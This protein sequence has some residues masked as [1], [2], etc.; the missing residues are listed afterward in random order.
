M[1]YFND[2]KIVF[3]PKANVSAGYDEGYEAG[4]EAGKQ[5]GGDNWYDTFWDAFQENGSRTK[6][7]DAFAYW[8]TEAF[9]PK[10]DIIVQNAGN[11]SMFSNAKIEGSLS[12]I[13]NELGIVLRF[14]G[15]YS[16]ATFSNS[17][18][19][20]I[21]ISSSI[22]FSTWANTF[23]GCSNLKTLKLPELY[24][25]ASFNNTFSG[26]TE[27]EEVTLTGTIG[28]S[29]SFQDS[30]KLTVGS[31]KNVLA[32]LAV[33]AGTDKDGVYKVTFPPECW[34]RLEASGTSPVGG[35]WKE[36]VQFNYGFSV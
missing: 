9:K 16:S 3:S 26:C 18:F 5:S 17:S 33:Y 25:G 14:N 20:E 4:F 34:E 10:Y 29:I 35:T 28:N 1:A 24:S 15:G 30:T 19:T 22:P 36:F 21:D 6:Y 13:L 11:Y 27:L 31:M 8:P 32:C 7:T 12:E 2:I 23:N